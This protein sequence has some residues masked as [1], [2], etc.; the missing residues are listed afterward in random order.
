MAARQLERPEYAAT[1]DGTAVTG[2]GATVAAAPIESLEAPAPRLPVEN[3]DRYELLSLLGSGGMGS[4]YKARDPRLGRLVAIKFIRSDDVRLTRRFLQEARAQARIEHA[5]ICKVYEVGEV[6]GKPYIAMQL[7][8]GMSLEQ[9]K[10]RLALLEKV[11]LVRDAALALHAAHALGVVHRDVK[12]ANVMIER[13]EDGRLHPIVM[14]FGLA[15]DSSAEEHLTQS[16]TV[17]GTPGYMAPEQAAGKLEQIDRRSDVYSLGA[18]LYDLLCGR[19]PFEGSSTVALLLQVLYQDPPPLRRLCPMVPLDLQ[20]IA[21]KC[22]L[23][24]PTLRYDSA[25]AL[26]EDLSRYLNDEPILARP[27]GRLPRLYRQARKHKLVVAASAVAF[28]SLL[29]LGAFALRARLMSAAQARV[30]AARAQRSEHLGQVIKELE[31]FLGLAQALPLHDLRPE[32]RLIERRIAEL[33]AEMS[34][35]PAAERVPFYYALGRG[36]LA[37]RQYDAARRWLEQALAAGDQ[38]P[39]LHY[40]LGRVLGEQ[41]RRELEVTRRSGDKSWL[42]RRDGE[43]A[44]LYLEPARRHLQ[45]AQGLELESPQYVAGLLALYQRDYSRAAA[46]ADEAT[47]RTPWLTEAWQLRAEVEASRGQDEQKRGEYENA[48]RSFERAATLYQQ[49]A[50]RARSNEETYS[51]ESTVWLHAAQL[52]LETG[53]NVAEPVAHGLAAWEHAAAIHPEHSELPLQKAALLTVQ[54]ADMIRRGGDPRPLHAQMIAAVQESLRRGST[55]PSAYC[56]LGRIYIQEGVYED[57]YG[58]SPV[59]AF[60]RA[61]QTFQTLQARQPEWA[62]SFALLGLAHLRQAIYL[63]QTGGDPRAVL[64]ATI[65]ELKK[66]IDLDDGQYEPYQNLG[67]AYQILVSYSMWH[68]LSPEVPLAELMQFLQ[69]ALAANRGRWFVHRALGS[70]E[71]QRASYLIEVAGEPE[72]ALFKALAHYQ[73]ALRLNC[74]EAVLYWD[75]ADLYMRIALSSLIRGSD[76]SAYIDRGLEAVQQGERLNPT[77]ASVYVIHAGLER[78]RARWLDHESQ[79]PDAPIRRAIAAARRA[80]AIKPNYGLAYSRL[81]EFYQFLAQSHAEHR[82]PVEPLVQEGL[83]AAEQAQRLGERAS[84][85]AARGA[86]FEVR[87]RGRQNLGDVAGQRQWAR[88]AVRELEAALAENRYLYRMYSWN[89]SRAEKMAGIPSR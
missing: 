41:Y 36:Y 16:G 69:T 13:G 48:R 85:R 15:R 24:E 73:D 55:D 77:D 46:S 9:A 86:L 43:L 25:R 61:L 20:T 1:V 62:V 23:K 34:A 8:Q 56:T 70:A 32:E 38:R 10:P 22:L 29:L 39:P 81:A 59:P 84:G 79:R 49:T 52:S 40:A 21:M 76:P 44:A 74:N 3:W 51:A 14:D 72:P 27:L 37:L 28:M 58:R 68:S 47:Q 12:P 89:L 50:D 33:H 78:L 87:A 67:T 5:G 17:M 63:S 53:A 4:V 19:P 7:V 26:A 57:A 80:I 54:T 11:Q 18:M 35:Q 31:L 66:A 82:E 88:Q 45:A 83:L 60:Q 42:Q 75:L 71:L 30:A 64:S 6:E 65:A 2:A